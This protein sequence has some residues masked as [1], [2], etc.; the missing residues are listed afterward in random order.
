MNYVR[1]ILLVCIFAVDQSLWFVWMS[2]D[3]ER[4]GSSR[5]CHITTAVAFCETVNISHCTNIPRSHIFGLIEAR[6]HQTSAIDLER[7]YQRLHQI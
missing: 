5:L 3:N 6:L 7:Q 2:V 1:G 4:Y